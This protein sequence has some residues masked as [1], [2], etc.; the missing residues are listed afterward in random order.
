M[1]SHFL[2][3]SIVYTVMKIKFF[4]HGTVISSFR[5]FRILGLKT[6][7]IISIR[8]CKWFHTIGHHPKDRILRIAMLIFGL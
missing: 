3:C 4:S 7:F 6:H 8:G 2:K 5:I 1:F